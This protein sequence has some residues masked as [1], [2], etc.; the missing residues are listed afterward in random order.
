MICFEYASLC[1]IPCPLSSVLF[2]FCPLLYDYLV[3]PKVEFHMLLSITMEDSHGSP[4]LC[5]AINNQNE[6]ALV[7]NRDSQMGPVD[8]DLERGL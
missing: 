6:V 4:I 3:V 2:S 5:E 8:E 7:L 1:T